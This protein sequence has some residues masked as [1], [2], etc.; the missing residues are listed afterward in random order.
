VDRH[1]LRWLILVSVL[2]A[3]FACR[4]EVFV[5][6]NGGRISGELLNRQ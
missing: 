4:A 2:N 6:A 1:L 3:G 5:L